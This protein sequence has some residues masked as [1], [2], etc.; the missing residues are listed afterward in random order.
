MSM[1]PG[2]SSG[3]RTP[4][5]EAPARGMPAQNLSLPAGTP[6]QR[7]QRLENDYDNDDG[8]ASGDIDLSLF[9][10]NPAQVTSLGRSERYAASANTFQPTAPSSPLVSRAPP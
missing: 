2:Y 10:S 5:S 3:T 1:H 8:S 6:R 7:E 4:V 9:P